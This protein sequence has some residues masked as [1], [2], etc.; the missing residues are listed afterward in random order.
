MQH[1]ANALRP[2]AFRHLALRGREVRG[3]GEGAAKESPGRSRLSRLRRLKRVGRW[4]YVE[5]SE[6]SELSSKSRKERRLEEGSE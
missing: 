5:A 1:Q 6:G 2:A 4:R 3:G